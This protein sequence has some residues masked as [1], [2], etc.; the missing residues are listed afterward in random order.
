M[1]GR[2]KADESA[3]SLCYEGYA[4]FN[5]IRTVTTIRSGIK[6]CAQFHFVM[7]TGR[8]EEKEFPSVLAH[9]L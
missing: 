9:L 8:G 1:S 2:Q 5:I 6:L 7:L 3:M 4:Y